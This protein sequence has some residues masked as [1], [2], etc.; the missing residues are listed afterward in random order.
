MLVT[1]EGR[2]GCRAG[3]YPLAQV[4]SS[5]YLN[6]FE[7]AAFA[8]GLGTC[9]A[10]FFTMGAKNWPPLQDAL[11]LPAGHDLCFAMM[12]GYP[13]MKY[14]LLPERKAPQIIWR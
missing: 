5:N 3:G 2:T 7:L 4:D 8:L 9:W 11:Q 13:K 12:V 14:H 1:H 6:T 10:G